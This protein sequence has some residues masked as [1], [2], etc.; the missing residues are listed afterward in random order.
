MSLSDERET[1]SSSGVTGG[2]CEGRVA[3]VTG[4]GRGIGAAIAALLAQGR[5]GPEIFK[6]F[7]LREAAEAH[8]LMESSAHIGKI[9]LRVAD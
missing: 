5:C 8:R 7:D 2:I 9:M 1:C 6:V 4:A 3:V